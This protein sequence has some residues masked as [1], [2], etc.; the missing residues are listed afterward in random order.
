MTALEAAALEVPTVAH[1]VGGLV[2][3][4]P[5]E[6]QVARHEVDGYRDGILRALR[7][8]GRTIAESHALAIL[9]HYSAERNAERIH[10]LY[11]QVAAE[12]A[13]GEPGGE[14]AR[15]DDGRQNNGL[16]S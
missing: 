16:N 3:V 1:A 5:C 7:A 15:D 10:A 2:E 14:P 13:A 11:E 9:K 12:A 4:V 6:F 8:D